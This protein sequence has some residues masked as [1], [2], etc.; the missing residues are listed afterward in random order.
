[1]V[2]RGVGIYIADYLE[3][4]VTLI[5]FDIENNE[6]IW[7]QMKIGGNNKMVFGSVY[8]SHSTSGENGFN[9]H[10]ILNGEHK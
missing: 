5:D 8:H 7:L 6:S 4:S 10:N 3:T 9:L 2:G 1:M